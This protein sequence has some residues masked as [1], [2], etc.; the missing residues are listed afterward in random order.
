MKKIKYLLIILL[1]LLFNNVSAAAVSCEIGNKDLSAN[2]KNSNEIIEVTTFIETTDA[3]DDYDTI[4]RNSTIIGN[5]K[6]TSDVVITASK[7]AIAGYNHAILNASTNNYYNDEYPEIYIYYGDIGGWYMLDENNNAVYISDQTKLSELNRRAIYAVN[8]VKKGIYIGETAED[9]I[10]ETCVNNGINAVR[11]G[12]NKVKLYLSSNYD[13]F[14]IKPMYANDEDG[15][16]AEAFHVS[17]DPDTGEY[18][19]EKYGIKETLVEASNIG[20]VRVYVYSGQT[21]G[22]ID[23]SIKIYYR[24]GAS[25]IVEV[26]RLGL[27]IPNISAIARF[28]IVI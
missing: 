19:I 16:E 9:S 11:I 6:F 27:L 10:G 22:Y 2:L 20:Q 17:Y 28:E 13:N 4:E 18:S 24:N 14:T 7:A 15:F 3:T 12:N 26:S 5:T 1:L 25:E 8:N 23:G 21:N